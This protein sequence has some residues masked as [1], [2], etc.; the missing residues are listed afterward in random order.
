MQSG[1]SFVR[2][3]ITLRYYLALGQKPNYWKLD[4]TNLQIHEFRVK[5]KY[6]LGSQ[7]SQEVPLMHSTQ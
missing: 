1:A 5:L 7:W 2:Y 3:P 4:K 6:M